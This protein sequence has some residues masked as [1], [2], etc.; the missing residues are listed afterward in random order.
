MPTNLLA[1][2]LTTSHRTARRA[3]SEG[4]TAPLT[5]GGFLLGLLWLVGY[6]LYGAI[7]LVLPYNYLVRR[8]APPPAHH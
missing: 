1:A 8:Q 7:L 6:S 2:C 4:F 3:Y 5:V